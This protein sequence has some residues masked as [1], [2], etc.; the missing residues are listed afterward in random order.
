MLCAAGDCRRSRRR[1]KSIARRPAFL[2][3]GPRRPDRAAARTEA[4][5]SP[6]QGARVP[7]R[8][9][10]HGADR[11]GRRDAG[12]GRRHDGRLRSRRAAHVVGERLRGEDP[13][14]A[15]AVARRGPL[16]RR[17]RALA[18]P[19]RAPL[20]RAV[21]ERVHHVAERKEDEQ[22]EDGAED[23]RCERLAVLE[24]PIVMNMSGAKMSARFP[25]RLHDGARPCGRSAFGP[26][27]SRSCSSRGLGRARRPRPR[28][29]RRPRR[30][31]RT[32]GGALS[33]AGGAACGLARDLA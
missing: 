2:R 19:L 17:Y 22:E 8:R 6:G 27:L 20:E 28:A 24:E 32:R 14:G 3:R 30:R 12:S 18:L 29:P 21:E 9:R 5:R 10:R 13:V 1:T 16:P 33:R 15:G 4:R 7:R 25:T 26:V 11:V 23:R 31:T